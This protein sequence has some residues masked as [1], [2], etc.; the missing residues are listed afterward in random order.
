METTFRVIRHVADIRYGFLAP[1][2][3]LFAVYRLYPLLEGLRL[4]FTNARLG[5]AS[6]Q[7]IGVANYTRLL[8]DDLFFFIIC[9]SP[10][11]TR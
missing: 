5:R 1:G 6:E 10:R 2:L 3:L 7:W 4:S 8:A 11:S 9:S